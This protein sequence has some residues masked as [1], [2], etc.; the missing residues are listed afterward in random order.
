[1]KSFYFVGGP[2]P[3]MQEK[4]IQ[5]LEEIGGSPQGWTI[6]P[7]VSEDGKA[8]HVVTVESLQDVLEH[9]AHFNGFY[10]Y[11]EI[12]EVHPARQ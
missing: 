6:F 12:I 1:M 7:H 3:G 11:G 4:F 10:E 8:L 9:V 2:K 5:R